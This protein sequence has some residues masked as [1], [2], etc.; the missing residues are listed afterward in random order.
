[1]RATTLWFLPMYASVMGLS[2]NLTP[3]ANLHH[4]DAQSAILNVTN[5]PAIAHPVA[6][7]SSVRPGQRL[8]RVAW[9]FQS[10]NA[11]V[12][13]VKD[14]PRHLFVELVQLRPLAVSAY[15]IVQA[16]V[17]SHISSG[18]DL[19]FPLTDTRK[20]IGSEVVVFHFLDALL[21]D[22]AQVK[23]L[24]ATSLRCEEVKPLLCLWSQTN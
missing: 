4:K 3:V 17:S 9:V 8:A 13:E 12:H 11:L 16:K 2:V 7:K 5:H 18:M 20:H 1:M 15:S 14:A 24:G 6:P 22:F 21:D 23:G 19:F 10:G